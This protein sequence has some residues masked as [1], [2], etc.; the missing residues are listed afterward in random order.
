[1][2][3]ILRRPELQVLKAFLKQPNMS[4]LK[5]RPP[6][7]RTRGLPRFLGSLSDKES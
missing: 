7:S 3:P 6:K 5:V 2:V 1:M 4:D